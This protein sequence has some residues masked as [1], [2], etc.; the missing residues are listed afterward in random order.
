MLCICSMLQSCSLYACTMP[1][2]VNLGHKVFTCALHTHCSV[3]ASAKYAQPNYTGQRVLSG[4]QTTRLKSRRMI[5]LLPPS[6]PFSRQQV[7]SL[8]QSS[9]VSPSSLLTGEGGDGGWGRSKIIRRRE[10]LVLLKGSG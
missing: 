8:S 4:L 6:P 9:C 3:Q 7:V 1:K 5:W 10:S 2:N